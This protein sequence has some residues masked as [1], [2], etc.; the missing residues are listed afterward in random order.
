M[1][2]RT[3][4]IGIRMAIGAS[5]SQILRLILGKAT[6]LTGL[7]LLIGATGAFAVTRLMS[8]LL[9]GIKAVDPLTFLLSPV[10]LAVIALTASYIPARRAFL[11]DP[12]RAL[13]NE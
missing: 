13:R 8:G 9:F 11:V 1:S 7:G 6:T 2:Q 10:L 12:V 5:R 4:E 3:R